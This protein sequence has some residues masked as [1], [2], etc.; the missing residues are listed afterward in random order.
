MNK[1]ECGI[2]FCVLN[3][4]RLDNSYR[5]I[6]FV[7]VVG[8]LSLLA[9][10]AGTGV[11]PYKLYFI[12]N[13][14]MNYSKNTNLNHFLYHHLCNIFFILGR[15]KR[16]WRQQQNERTQKEQE[17]EAEA[18]KQ[19]LEK[20]WKQKQQNNWRRKQHMRRHRNRKKFASDVATSLLALNKN[21]KLNIVKKINLYINWNLTTINSK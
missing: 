14:K 11:S 8:F 2:W 15:S 3:E 7:V 12:P 21:G 9:C 18:T 10:Y 4:Y 5:L 6:G 16:N 20:N 1:I 19:E 13:R 17:A